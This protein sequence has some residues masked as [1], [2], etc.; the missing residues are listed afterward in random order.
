V[1]FV[2]DQ[3]IAR[4]LTIMEQRMAERV[5]VTELAALVNLSS[6]GLAHLFRRSVGMSPLRYLRELRLRRACDL[7]ETTSLPVREVM[8]LVGCTD[9][10][11][12]SRNFRL[13]FGVTPREY[14]HDRRFARTRERAVIGRG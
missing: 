13:R 7:L 11:H 3:R 10:S 4:V 5:R 2:L 12:F 14:R 1:E 9:P 8:R 6:S